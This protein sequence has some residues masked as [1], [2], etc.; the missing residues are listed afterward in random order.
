[1]GRRD[2]I[3][4]DE[5]CLHCGGFGWVQISHDPDVDI[6]CGACQGTGRKDNPV[7][8]IDH[9]A[10]AKYLLAQANQN[11]DKPGV[12]A[13]GL[14]GAQVHATL[15]LAEQQRIANRIALA[16]L[17]A[18]TERAFHEHGNRAHL[19][20]HE[21]SLYRHPI[22]PEGRPVLHDDIREGLRL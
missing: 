4:P 8:R 18:E 2:T 22:H 10:S 9:Y 1:M 15:A 12:A 14:A 21:A 13:V 6:D 5:R 16:A 19:V 7:T 11:Q 3:P 17:V 20:G